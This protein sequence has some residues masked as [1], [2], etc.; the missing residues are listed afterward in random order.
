M[1]TDTKTAAELKAELATATEDEARATLAAEQ[2]KGDQARSTVVQA[3]EERLAVL[4][5]PGEPVTGSGPS[6]VWAQLLD[7]DGKP[8]KVDGA[9][10]A[11]ELTPLTARPKKA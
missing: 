8:V 1:S 10:V 3:A 2:Q 4:A 11:A 6:G 9:D 7:D 5:V